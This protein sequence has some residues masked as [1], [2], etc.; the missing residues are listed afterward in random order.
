M[1]MKH[2]HTVG[3]FNIFIINILLSALNLHLIGHF[4]LPLSIAVLYQMFLW[5]RTT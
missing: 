3:N 2:L 4:L 5:S 1:F